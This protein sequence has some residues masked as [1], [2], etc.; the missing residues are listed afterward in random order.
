MTDAGKPTVDEMRA[1][2]RRHGLDNLTTEHIARMVDLASYVADLGRTLPR[3]PKKDD[4]PTSTF[5]VPGG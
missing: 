1:W 3:P 4:M 2:V 5:A